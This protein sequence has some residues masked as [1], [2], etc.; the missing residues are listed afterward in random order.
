MV[1]A[2]RQAAAAAE[3]EARQ[4]GAGAGGVGRGPLLLARRP[5]LLCPRRAGRP[6]TPAA[7]RAFATRAPGHCG[8]KV[9]ASAAAPD[10]LPSHVRLNFSCNVVAVS[11]AEVLETYERAINAFSRPVDP[12]FES[13]VQQVGP[14]PRGARAAAADRG[15]A[16]GAGGAAP[17]AAGAPAGTWRAARRPGAPAA[18]G[19]G[20]G[21]RGNWRGA[22]AE[23]GH[24]WA[25]D[26]PPQ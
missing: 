22:A 1:K 18:R 20:G 4:A 10:P 11:K 8:G 15:S 12:D 16:G 13:G 24:R 19:G 5:C 26:P 25:W 9:D 3:V 2:G 6:Q 14:A 23:P 17:C 21:A 7:P